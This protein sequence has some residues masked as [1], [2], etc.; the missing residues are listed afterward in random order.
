VVFFEPPLSSFLG[1]IM[2][3]VILFF[4]LC[5]CVVPFC[6]SETASY[7]YKQSLV[8][9]NGS[10]IELREFVSGKR[11]GLELYYK[12]VV[13]S[14]EVISNVRVLSISQTDGSYIL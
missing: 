14:E 13:D 7:H 5:I 4:V 6:F 9:A 2:Q 12:R 3:R 1:D 10:F 8:I 11:H